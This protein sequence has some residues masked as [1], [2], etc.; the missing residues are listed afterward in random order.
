MKNNE[1][2]FCIFYDWVESLEFLPRESVGDILFALRD[3]YTEGEDT[4]ERFEGAER[5]LVK[6]MLAQI[7]RAE[8]RGAR[9]EYSTETNTETET[10]AETE[11][12]TE[13]ETETEKNKETKTNTLAPARS[14]TEKETERTREAEE[15]E[16]AFHE[17]EWEGE[18]ETFKIPTLSEVREYAR[19]EGLRFVEPEQFYNYNE[20]HRWEMNGEPIMDW[21]GAMKRWNGKRRAAWEARS[22]REEGV[23]E[24]GVEDGGASER[25][26]GERK[27]KYSDGSYIGED[28]CL[29][30]ERGKRRYG[31][32]DVEEAFKAALAR[33]Y[34][35]EE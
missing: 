27:I 30:S 20:G 22:R 8:A 31:D 25:G 16:N 23:S 10:K 2:G 13:T 15:S 14:E 28:G 1:R 6:M 18:R 33:T 24:R 26:A 12:E 32:F 11:A 29:Y 3:Y 17:G 4:S 5:A 19:T 21:R 34:G 35:E 9:V 7:R